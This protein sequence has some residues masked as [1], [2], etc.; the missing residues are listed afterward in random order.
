MT[1]YFGTT[2]NAHSF[3]VED[4]QSDALYWYT[5]YMYTRTYSAIRTY[6]ELV[7]HYAE[8]ANV[9]FPN[10]LADWF[11]LILNVRPRI[12]A[13]INLLYIYIYA[14]KHIRTIENTEKKFIQCQSAIL[15]NN[16]CLNEYIYLYIY[17]YN[18][19]MI[20]VYI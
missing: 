3:F 10:L 6:T 13:T 18:I 4:F 11:I 16:T 9:S 17:I 12:T 20:Y 19:Y 1:V 5:E 14:R 15:F 2:R 7:P 8:N